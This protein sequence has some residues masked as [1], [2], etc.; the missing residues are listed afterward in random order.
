MSSYKSFETERLLLIPTSESDSDFVLSLF[1]TPKW[2]ANIGDRGVYSVEDAKRYIQERMRPQ[3]ERLGFSNYTIVRKSDSAKIGIC[4]LYDRAGLDGLDIGFALLPEF[5]GQGFAFEAV[6]RLKQAA[7]D[8]FGVTE[9]LAITLPENVLSQK[10]LEKLGLK[11][12][13][14]FR[15]PNDNEDLFLFRI[16]SSS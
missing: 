9:I 12:A 16:T 3:L 2:L 8:E 6:N 14:L 7:F 4:G 5:E 1:N 15:L 13:G 11:Y 10:L